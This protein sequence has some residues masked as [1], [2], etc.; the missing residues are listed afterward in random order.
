M[1][2]ITSKVLPTGC[3]NKNL[4]VT[5]GSI[6]SQSQ[7]FS[8]ES[9]RSQSSIHVNI[10][11]PGVTGNFILKH[12]VCC[13]DTTRSPTSG[14]DT[15][16]SLRTLLPGRRCPGPVCWWDLRTGGSVTTLL[17]AQARQP[18]IQPNSASQPVRQ[19]DSQSRANPN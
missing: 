3:F 9:N 14:S 18:L 1:G 13:S 11:V 12:P 2:V 5:P 15:V 19:A 8:T 4:P 7:A 6:L 17:A 10:M 16:R